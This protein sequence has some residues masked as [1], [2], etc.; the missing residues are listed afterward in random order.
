MNRD[1]EARMDAYLDRHEATIVAELAQLCAQPSVSATGEGIAAAAEGVAA[2]LAPARVRGRG[3]AHS[4]G[5]RWCYAER[6]GRASAHCSSTTTTT[7]SRPSRSRCGSPRPSRPACATASSSR[8]ARAT[9]R[10]TSSAGWRRWMP[11]SRRARELPC[12]VKFVIE[13]EEEIS[14]PNLPAFVED[15]PRAWPP[16]GASGNSAAWMKRACRFRRWGCAASATWNSARGAPPTTHTPDSADRSFP[17]R[18]GA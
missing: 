15:N 11:C 3:G 18:P 2:A 16:T 6:A 5:I 8:A 7:C 1:L 17:T 4:A 14:S 12:R 13:G 10:G 9:T